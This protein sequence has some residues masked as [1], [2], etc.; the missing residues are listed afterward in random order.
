MI[1]SFILSVFHFLLSMPHCEC[2]VYE[3]C[4]IAHVL[5][6]SI[7]T[8]AAAAGYCLCSAAPTGTSPA[9][10]SVAFSSANLG[11][12]YGGGRRPSDLRRPGP[13]HSCRTASSSR[14]YTAASTTAR[15]ANSRPTD[16]DLWTAAANRTARGSV[17]RP[18]SAGSGDGVRCP[19][20]GASRRGHS[21]RAAGSRTG[22]G[23]CRWSTAGPA[24]DD[25]PDAAA[26]A[27]R[28]VHAASGGQRW[29]P[30]TGAVHDS[31][32]DPAA[33]TSS[34]V[35]TGRQWQTGESC[36]SGAV[37]S[38]SSQL[39]AS[40]RSWSTGSSARTFGRLECWYAWVCTSSLWKICSL[41]DGKKRTLARGDPTTPPW[42]GHGI[43]PTVVF[44]H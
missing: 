27:D 23:L 13:G 30:P 20:G 16:C 32:T 12:R 28:R 43:Q 25:L 9:S 4:C 34:S 38:A 1:L 3:R 36:G 29:R 41:D 35:P 40:R 17:L 2:I 8:A 19:A 21:V 6:R 39:A 18:A 14:L 22:T 15:P 44:S 37:R 10:G 24:G 42:M 7:R 31:P 5:F 33:P 26:T 11:L